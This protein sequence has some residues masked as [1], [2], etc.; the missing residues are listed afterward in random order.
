MKSHTYVSIND[1]SDH[2]KYNTHPY[3][4]QFYGSIDVDYFRDP[5]NPNYAICRHIL[6]KRDNT[7]IVYGG[8]NP[9]E[10]ECILENSNDF[11]GFCRGVDL[12]LKSKPYRNVI[13]DRQTEALHP[14]FMHM[15]NL[16]GSWMLEHHPDIQVIC[17]SSSFNAPRHQSMV[18]NVTMAGIAG[19]MY[20]IGNEAC[21]FKNSP[22]EYTTE[23]R[24]KA[25]LNLNRLPKPARVLAMAKFNQLGMLDQ[26]LTSMSFYHDMVRDWS[27]KVGSGQYEISRVYGDFYRDRWFDQSTT[28]VTEERISEIALIMESEINRYIIEPGLHTQSW[29]IDN[30]DVAGTNPAFLVPEERSMFRRTWFSFINETHTNLYFNI[31]ELKNDV[32][33]SEKTTKSLFYKHPFVLFCAPGALDVLKDMGFKTFDNIIDESYDKITDPLHR[34]EACVTE[35]QKLCK[36]SHTEWCDIHTKIIDQIEHNSDLITHGNFKLFNFDKPLELV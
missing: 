6:D 7:L 8:N 12:A 29:V 35:A 9:S 32:F 16:F 23:V 31:H 14:G 3:V 22:S 4:E 11:E 20:G 19:F 27:H 17:I 24:E 13:V 10:F 1:L 33:L 25:M 36:Y 2:I 5:T 15:L 21:D 30:P 18:T 28:A 34:L 26:S